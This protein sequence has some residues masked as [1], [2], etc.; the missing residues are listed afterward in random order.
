MV[1]QAV[2]KSK[3]FFLRFRGTVLNPYVSPVRSRAGTM[4]VMSVK[5]ASS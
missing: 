4:S 5:T 1:L 2:N 3:S